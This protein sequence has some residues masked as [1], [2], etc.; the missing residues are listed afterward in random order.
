M[1]IKLNINRL[2]Y[3]I[4][5]SIID[6]FFVYFVIRIVYKTYLHFKVSFSERPMFLTSYQQAIWILIWHTL[7]IILNQPFPLE[8]KLIYS[9]YKEI[10]SFAPSAWSLFVNS[11]WL[12]LAPKCKSHDAYQWQTTERSYSDSFFHPS[13]YLWCNRGKGGDRN[14][15]RYA[16]LW[17]VVP[18][19]I[20]C[21]PR[22]ARWSYHPPKIVTSMSQ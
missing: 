17:H 10:V 4:I 3:L 13:C 19:F 20:L 11:V 14:H 18:S 2:Y 1:H 9:G 8:M 21:Q 12:R 7:F 22:I 6:S 15:R 5:I 16:D